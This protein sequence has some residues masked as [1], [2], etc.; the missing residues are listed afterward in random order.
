MKAISILS[1][2][3]VLFC[4]T[5]VNAKTLP[6]PAAKLPVELKSEI[7]KH[8]TYPQEAKSQLIEGDVW[9]KVCVDE[10]SHVKVVDL[11]STNP[12]LGEYVKQEL[13]SLYLENPGCT[14]GE[15][16]YLK[17]RFDLTELK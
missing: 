13:S 1:I 17:V 9:L 14:K 10:E 7:M 11:S 16:F 15:V 8:L 2:V 4:T 5:M 3:M 12:D 6:A